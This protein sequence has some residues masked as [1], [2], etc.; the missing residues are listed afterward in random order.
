[1]KTVFRLLETGAWQI[2]A[3][4]RRKYLVWTVRAASG[5]YLEVPFPM[6]GPQTGS[7][8]SFLWFLRKHNWKIRTLFIQR[9]VVVLLAHSIHTLL[10][11]RSSSGA[12]TLEWPTG[13][14]QASYSV[15][16]SSFKSRIHQDPL[17]AMNY[18]PSSL[19]HPSLYH[20]SIPNFF[21]SITS[22]LHL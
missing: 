15:S 6:N 19:S 10:V 18:F 11:R 13:G 1:M 22:S 3:K 4:F 21:L 2:F 7:K 8:S 17:W 9:E 16:L 12:S 20:L 5:Y 14:N